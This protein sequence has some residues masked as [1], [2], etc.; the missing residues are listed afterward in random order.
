M[1]IVVTG[2]TGLTGSAVVREL[3]RLGHE[4]HGTIRSEVGRSEV[5]TLGAKPAMADLTDPAQLARAIA[6][7][8][9]VVHVAGIRLGGT[10]ARSGIDR[11]ARVVVVSTAAVYSRH[12]GARAA[13]LQGED[14]IR[15]VA[16]GSVFVRPTM[17]YGSR[18]DRNVHRVIAFAKRWR[19][20]PL[21]D[22]GR[23]L[24]QPIHY[25]DLAT[26]I[27]ALVATDASGVVDAGG[28]AAISLRRAASVILSAL[29]L[30]ERFVPLPLMLAI[31]LARLVDAASGSRW[32]ER[33]ERTREHRTV[34]NAR[35]LELT[36]VALRPFEDGVR[37][38]VAEMER[39]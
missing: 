10:L 26:L 19:F 36:R 12:Q 35:A 9:A 33:L 27:A 38:E 31:P 18:R 13:Y 39:R 15:A 37:D 32:T 11:P 1:R 7:A 6:G 23:S 17:I 30:P 21:P 29:R 8:D 5:A 20:V 34:D 3:V 25:A 4:V 28:P 14:L 2:A 22:G 16:P 24:I